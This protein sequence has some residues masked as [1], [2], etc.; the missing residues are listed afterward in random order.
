M[1]RIVLS[2]LTP[3]T[4]IH[5]DDK[6]V[7]LKLNEIPGFNAFLENVVERFGESWTNVTYTGNGYGISAESIPQIYN[8]VLDD[9]RILGVQTS[10]LVSALW[11]YFISSKSVGGKQYRILLTSGAIDLLTAEEFDFLIGHELGHY[12]CGHIPYHMLVEALYMPLF[13]YGVGTEI[14]TIVKLPLLKWYRISHYSADRMGL[15]CCQDINVALS[16]MIKMAGIPRKYYDRINVKEFIK[17]SDDFDAS[18]SRKAEK[19]IKE[20]M[21]RSADS[22]WMVMR[23]KKLLDWYESGAY[24]EIINQQ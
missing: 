22:P 10:P 8:Q 19:L 15:L 7:I 18:Y 3:E 11:G 2:N 14:A 24:N 12:L 1:S 17:Q 13:N 9:C 21:I 16:A 4:T 6:A 20:L 23:A 5:P